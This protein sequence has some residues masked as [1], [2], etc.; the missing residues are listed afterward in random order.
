M[1]GKISLYGTIV[2]L[3]IIFLSSVVIGRGLIGLLYV[4]LAIIGCFLL[5]SL[6]VKLFS[7]LWFRIFLVVVSI[8]LFHFNLKSWLFTF[9]WITIILI[10]TIS[11]SKFVNKKWSVI[12]EVLSLVSFVVLMAIYE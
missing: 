10:I 4:L 6:L 8:L 1:A 12:L 9:S 2:G 3:V 5:T 7:Y 11:Q